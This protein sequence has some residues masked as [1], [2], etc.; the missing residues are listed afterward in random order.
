MVQSK[1][2][3]KGCFFTSIPVIA[4]HDGGVVHCMS[5]TQASD[6]SIDTNSALSDVLLM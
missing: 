6:A 5:P 2:V 3:W 4:T 1:V